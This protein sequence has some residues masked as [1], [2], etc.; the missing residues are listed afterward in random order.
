MLYFYQ[1]QQMIGEGHSAFRGWPLLKKRVC[2][3]W[4]DIYFPDPTDVNQELFRN[5]KLEGQVLDITKNELTQECFVVVSVESVKNPLIVS[6]NKV[7]FLE[8]SKGDNAND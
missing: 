3:R 2:F 6:L 8:N 5:A 4:S 1:A 7:K